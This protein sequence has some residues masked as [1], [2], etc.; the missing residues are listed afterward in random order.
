[1]CGTWFGLLRVAFS[2]LGLRKVFLRAIVG[3]ARSVALTRRFRF[4]HEGWL[5]KEFRTFD[6]EWVDLDSY[7]LL[8]EHVAPLRDARSRAV[9]G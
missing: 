5:R 8:A 7:G 2:E 9:G 1:M 3:N 6:G 4:S